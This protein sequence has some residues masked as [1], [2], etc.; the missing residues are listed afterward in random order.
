MWHENQLVPSNA[1][2]L[3]LLSAPLM[4][5]LVCCDINRFRRASSGDEAMA[6]RQKEER[7]AGIASCGIVRRL[8]RF[9][10]RAPPGCSYRERVPERCNISGSAVDVC[11]DALA[12]TQR[13]ERAAAGGVVGVAHALSGSP[14][15]RELMRSVWLDLT[16]IIAAT[17]C[18]QRNYVERYSR[19]KMNRYLIGLWNVDSS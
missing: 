7:R 3:Y 16:P 14:V 1:V 10:S 8:G 12:W 4:I 19:S 15:H 5:L 18:H 6:R 2:S 13:A 11:S 9:S 17:A